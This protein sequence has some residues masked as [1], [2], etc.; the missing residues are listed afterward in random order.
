M[1]VL[2]TR[3]LAF[4]SPGIVGRHRNTPLTTFSIQRLNDTHAGQPWGVSMCGR[5]HIAIRFGIVGNRFD[6]ENSTQL[7]D[8]L[9]SIKILTNLNMQK[10]KSNSI[11]IPVSSLCSWLETNVNAI[12]ADSAWPTLRVPWAYRGSYRPAADPYAPIP[13]WNR[14]TWERTWQP[15]RDCESAVQGTFVGC[16]RVFCTHR[17]IPDCQS[18]RKQK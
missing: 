17:C 12:A 10:K 2:K 3:C 4:Q 1:K 6:T 8:Q 16:V 5:H 13:W 9:K 7:V 11:G 18:E 14:C 15:D